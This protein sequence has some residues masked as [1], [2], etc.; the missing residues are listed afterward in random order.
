MN[1][2]LTIAKNVENMLARFRAGE[3][4]HRRKFYDDLIK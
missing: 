2:K 4:G 3:N 1:A